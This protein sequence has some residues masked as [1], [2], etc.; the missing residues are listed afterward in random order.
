[1]IDFNDIM[2]VKVYV[3][4]Y[5]K[6]IIDFNDIM[7]VK[8]YVCIYS[9]IMIDFN[10]MSCQSSLAENVS[11]NVAPFFYHHSVVIQHLVSDKLLSLISKENV[12]NVR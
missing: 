10:D 3:C 9:K 5:S 7:V 2:V 6:I 1:M 8:V 12:H 11:C 4:I